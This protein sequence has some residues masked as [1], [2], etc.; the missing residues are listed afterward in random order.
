M[1]LDKEQIRQRLRNKLQSKAERLIEQ[2]K[3][4][5]QYIEDFKTKHLAE[6]E[7]RMEELNKMLSEGEVIMADIDA[8]TL[9]VKEEGSE[10]AVRK[11][12]DQKV[13]MEQNMKGWRD[14]LKTLEDHKTTLLCE[15]TT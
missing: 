12:Q 13:L 9:K 8:L 14:A 2:A 7:E 3:A 15:N 4:K 11:L 10:L 1:P 6:T 5:R